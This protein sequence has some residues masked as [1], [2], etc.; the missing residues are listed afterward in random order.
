VGELSVVEGPIPGRPVMALRNPDWRVPDGY[1]EEEWIVEGT[2]AGY[3]PVG[4]LEADGRWQVT[5]AESAP[6]CTR[7]VVR[8]PADPARHNGAVIVEW[9]NVTAGADAA[10]AWMLT[11]RHLV[12]EGF[13]WV[14]VSIQRA[15]VEGG[16]LFPGPF[17]KQ[18]DPVRYER[19]THPGDRFSF[20][21]FSQA[22]GLVRD[23]AGGTL[24]PLTADRVLGV[25]VSQSAAFLSGY[26]DAVAP[27]HRAF[28]GY[29]VQSRTGGVP[30]L[31]GRGPIG[32]QPDDAPPLPPPSLIRD[33]LTVPVIN[34]QTETDLFVL[35]S[36]QARQPDSE[37]FRLWEIA[38]SSHADTYLMN[39][40]AFHDDDTSSEELA[41]LCRPT[42]TPMGP[43]L[44][45]TAPV[46][47]GLQ[48]HYV[49][50]AALS[51]LD[52][53]VREGTPPPSAGR[54][55]LSDDGE[56]VATDELGVAR[57]GIRTGFVDVPAVAL[58]GT[59]PAGDQFAFLF[60]RSTP[61]PAEELARRYPRGVDDYTVQFAAAT[62]AAVRVG[63][64]LAADQH[65]LDAVARAMY[66][67]L[68][69]GATRPNSDEAAS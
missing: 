32:P 49:T 38:G 65:E 42:T 1:V 59:A 15:G 25:G 69:R 30:S 10:P 22:G 53:W 68:A 61:L 36:A 41:E 28:D 2:V 46:N 13:A 60:G 48:H 31:D 29:W 23:G 9:L 16:G 37:W 67:E 24:G 7:L 56:S 5:E 27:I 40:T 52:R 64:V 57:G 8:R 11:H 17:L 35:G 12:R 14:G 20:D 4:P 51:H 6:V 66:P 26:L 45:T 39:G 3:D 50:Q 54:I 18:V 43:D 63:F 19:L 44:P 21:L 58:S 62:A 33:D 55:E 34:V 47:C